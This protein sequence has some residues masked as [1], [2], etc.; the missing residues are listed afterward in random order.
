MSDL[1]REVFKETG[2]S[3]SDAGI[4]INKDKKLSIEQAQ[5]QVPGMPVQDLQKLQQASID[6]NT[7]TPEGKIDTGKIYIATF[8]VKDFSNMYINNSNPYQLILIFVLSIFLVL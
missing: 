8:T 6:L 3:I 5:Q 2:V 7:L 4:D 1:L